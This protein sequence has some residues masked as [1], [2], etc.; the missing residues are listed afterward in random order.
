MLKSGDASPLI[1]LVPDEGFRFEFYEQTFIGRRKFI[2]IQAAGAH[3][4]KLGATERPRFIPAPLT[5]EE[6][7]M[8]G[9]LRIFVSHRLDARADIHLDPQFLAQFARETRFER[10]LRLSLAPWKL[11]QAAQVNVIK[12]TRDEQ[13]ALAEDQ[14][15]SDIDDLRHYRPM[16]L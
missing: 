12:T 1:V 5:S 11:P 16:L 15:G 10:F 13:F 7:Q 14:P 3:P 6:L 4:G 2:R 9:L 8:N